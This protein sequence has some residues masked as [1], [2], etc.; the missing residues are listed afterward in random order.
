MV[1]QPLEDLESEN[2]VTHKSL[3]FDRFCQGS[4]EVVENLCT[5][6][7]LDVPVTEWNLSVALN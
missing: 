5:W 1:E 2:I 3:T 4:I 6:S 7:H